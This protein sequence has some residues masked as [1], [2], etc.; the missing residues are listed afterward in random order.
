MIDEP[1]RW[2]EAIANRREYIENELATGSPTVGLSFPDGILFLTF[3]RERRKIF[4]VYDRIAM[5]A[6][7]HPGD[8]ERLRMTAIELA[9]TEGFTRSAADVSL[10]RM[11]TYSFS[12]ALKQAFEQVYGAPYLARLLFAEVGATPVDDLFVALDYDGSMT[13]NSMSSGKGKD[14][15]AVISGTRRSAEQI[16]S[17]LRN[18]QVG[19][20]NSSLAVAVR[21]W[22]VGLY[23]MDEDHADIP[24]PGELKNFLK[25][26]L[27]GYSAEA[28]LLERK[29]RTRIAFAELGEDKL[30]SVLAEYKE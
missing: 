1:Y 24:S 22:G 11:A 13:A 10:R 25:T 17:F 7:G 6:I 29:P 3:G 20:L 23:T 30:A 9:G 8:I 5:G 28:A 4:E 14:H 16:S 19:P 18:E 27:K 15:F 26:Q 21:A 12:P 2:V